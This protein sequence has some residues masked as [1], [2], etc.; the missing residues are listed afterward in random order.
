MF[1][2]NGMISV[3]PFFR[4]ECH[5]ANW[6]GEVGFADRLAIFTGSGAYEVILFW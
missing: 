5:R 1:S 6:H 3:M 4:S 2:W